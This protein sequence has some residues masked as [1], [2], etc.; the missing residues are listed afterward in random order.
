MGK[1]LI[2]VIL[3]LVVAYVIV[4]MIAAR[5]VR[6]RKALKKRQ[7]DEILARAEQQT[8]WLLSGDLRGLYGDYPIPDV[9]LKDEEPG[10]MSLAQA[11]ALIHPR[12]KD[13]EAELGAH[14]R[15]G[16]LPPRRYAWAMLHNGE[17]GHG[18]S[19]ALTGRKRVEFDKLRGG[20]VTFSMRGD[21][22]WVTL[23]NAE[24]GG[25]ELG[26]MQ[27][28]KVYLREGGDVVVGLTADDVLYN[29]LLT[30]APADFERRAAAEELRAAGIATKPT[31]PA[32]T[33][34]ED[35]A[36]NLVAHL[37]DK[38]S[39]A[40]SVAEAQQ[41]L[42]EAKHQVEWA[43][44]SAYTA[45][46]LLAQINAAQPSAVLGSKTVRP[47]KATPARKPAKRAAADAAKKR[48][49]EETQGA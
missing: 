22:D 25:T 1:I 8:Q 43:H 45:N 47:K 48:P 10:H 34:I 29:R 16:L 17:P 46:A 20:S 12:P 39:A 3:L 18:T 14:D 19:I 15:D 13:T 27:F 42:D 11:E 26:R 38:Y 32:G 41:M 21:A 23:W 37:Q 5:R 2:L 49:L 24:V 6:K 9:F 7:T 4:G 31:H 33:I 30:G 36:G 35:W 28:T 44:G 40:L